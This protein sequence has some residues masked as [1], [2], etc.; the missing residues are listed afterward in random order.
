MTNDSDDNTLGR[1][2]KHLETARR[3]GTELSSKKLWA[4]TRLRPMTKAIDQVAD[5]LATAIDQVA[6]ELAA[7]IDLVASAVVAE[8]ARTDNTEAANRLLDQS[9][10]R[11]ESNKPSI[12]SSR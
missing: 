7:A 12:R 4:A 11:L 9:V 6:D 5:E 3:L 8:R 1:A 2:S 10:T